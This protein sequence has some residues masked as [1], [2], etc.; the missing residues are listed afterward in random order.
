MRIT[1]RFEKGEAV[2]FLSH[3]DTQRLL[4]RALRR[5]R[6]PLA[7]SRG[8]NPHPQLSFATA[9]SVGCTSSAEWLDIKLAEDMQPDELMERVNAA[10]PAGVRIL[11]A[12]LAAENA[13]TLS[14]LM[15]AV[16]YHTE[17][18][19]EEPLSEE[20]IAKE[21]ESFLEEPIMVMKKTKSGDKIVDIRPMVL[22]MELSGLENHTDAKIR[23][24]GRMDAAGSLNADLL[25]NAFLKAVGHTA[26]KRTHRTAIYTDKECVLPKADF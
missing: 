21:I 4:Q 22:K 6:I 19:F 12:H 18:F 2:R 15:C 23:L 24:I 20:T 17:L 10:L 1:V 16:E 11:E 5:A 25:L 26:E 9:L 3:L 7:Y 14:T 8:F 13:P